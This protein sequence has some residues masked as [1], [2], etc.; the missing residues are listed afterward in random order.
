[1][2]DGTPPGLTIGDRSQGYEV[3]GRG[4]IAG[5]G[6]DYRGIDTRDNDT[7]IALIE[8]ATNQDQ[9]E[10]FNRFRALEKMAPDSAL[11]LGHTIVRFGSGSA[12]V[13]GKEHAPALFGQTLESWIDHRNGVLV[14]QDPSATI[15][16]DTIG[17]FGAVL[18][19]LIAMHERGVAHGAISA[20]NVFSDRQGAIRLFGPWQAAGARAEATHKLSQAPELISGD[21]PNPASDIYSLASL[22]Y[23]GVTGDAPP[24][25]D[26]RLA[27][28]AQRDDDP[29]VPLSE[30]PWLQ[31]E[32]G[33]E[34]AVLMD[35]AMRLHPATRPQSLVAFRYSLA[36]ITERL[37]HI[38]EPPPIPANTPPPISSADIGTRTSPPPLPPK[39]SRGANVPTIP[40]RSKASTIGQAPPPLPS[41]SPSDSQPRRKRKIGIGTIVSFGA[42]LALA[43]WVASG[44]MFSSGESE[45][46][47]RETPRPNPVESVEQPRKGPSANEQVEDDEQDV[48]DGV[49]QQFC[50]SRFTWE[51]A[52]D[53]GTNALRAYV[54]RCEN[55]ESPFVDDAREILGLN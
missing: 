22:Y 11:V 10:L 3:T 7:E 51:T 5:Y 39:A 4:A 45:V 9:S 48:A 25:A 26:D 34:F 8:L 38:P 33:K 46:P 50:N 31:D 44:G 41:S 13:I 23:L 20:T 43:W 35:S 37:G 27:A 14:A 36:S 29:Y 6:A 54:Q 40:K 32:V 15:V 47:V 2:E 53:S 12:V 16:P 24:S 17:M 30:H 18:D 52:R 21:A 55:I 42:A 49:L 19:G 28:R 1:M